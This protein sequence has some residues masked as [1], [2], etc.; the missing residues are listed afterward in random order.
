MTVQIK[1]TSLLIIYTGG[2]IG[3]V[4]HPVTGALRPFPFE[5]IVD[6][7]PELKKAG[8]NLTTYT[9]CP[10]LDSANV[11]PQVWI[12]LANLI[13]ENYNRFDGFIVLHGTDTMAY[14]A[15]V[16]SF[17]LENLAKPVIFT[18]SQLPI[19]SMRTDAKENLVT[20]IEIAASHKDGRPVVPEVA[21]FFQ[22]KLFRG[23]RITKHNAEEFKAFQ[24]YNYPP[25]AESGVHIKYNY[26]AIDYANPKGQF[27]ISKKLDSNVAI[28]KI[29]PGIG[30]NVVKTILNIEGLRGVV[31][32]TYGSGNAPNDPWF[33][34]E[35]SEACEKGIVILNVTQCAEGRVEMGMYQTSIM[36]R[37]S[38][39]ISGRDI[40][41]EAAVAKLMF[42]LG[43]YSSTKVVT[44][45]LN[46]SLRGE[47]TV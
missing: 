29:F 41:T 9:Y 28:L 5:N 4:R 27:G 37:E 39:I 31:I 18:G 11:N 33:I 42:L 43:K 45:K 36:L 35:I 26:H 7:I 20:A 8:F 40:T 21:V 10:A 13:E 2:T 32:E 44:D 17:M 16:L 30:Q 22:S 19:G 46:I 47:M 34:T 38:G 1:P 24:S 14:S 6:E 15:S 12:D 3:M 25:L 23:N